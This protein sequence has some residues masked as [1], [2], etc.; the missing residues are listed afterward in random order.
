MNNPGSL[1]R[2]LNEHDRVLNII[3]FPTHERY[4]KQLCKTGHNFFAANLPNFKT[5]SKNHVMP[6]NYFVL[7]KEDFLNIRYDLVLVHSRFN[8]QLQVALNLR[9]LFNIPVLVLDHSQPKGNLPPKYKEYLRQLS[10]DVNVFITEFSRDLWDINSKF[11]IVIRHGIDTNLFKP[12]DDV[13]KEDYVLAVANHIATREDLYYNDFLEMVSG[14]DY[15]IIGDNPG[16]SESVNTDEEL[17]IEYNKCGIYVNTGRTPVPMSLLEAMACGCAVITCD[18]S[19]MPEFIK[20]GYNG[21]VTND[22]SEVRKY[23]QA[24]KD[25]PELRKTLGENARQTVIKEFS[26]ETFI[27][28]WNSVFNMLY[29]GTIT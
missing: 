27:N 17:V 8:Q 29:E 9:N 25:N 15:K 14:F 4:E 1:F 10:G 19:I 5:W 7:P 22:I 16:I 23:I 20:N 12:I 28:K 2:H 3:T 24:I 13:Q 26:E 21:F 6:S 18:Y 11:N